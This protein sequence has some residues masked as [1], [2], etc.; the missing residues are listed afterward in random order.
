MSEVSSG[1][2]IFWVGKHETDRREG[3]VG[4]AIRTSLLDRVESPSS[5]SDRIMRTR[6]SLAG[7][8]HLTLLSIYA[9]TLQANEQILDSFYGC[10]RDTIAM[11]P[12]ADKLIL[13][14]DFNAR[15]GNDNQTWNVLGPFGMG[16]MNS[17]GLRLLELCSEFDLNICNTFF[18]QKTIHKAT[19]YHPRSKH[20]HLIDYIIT[21]KRDFSDVCSVR[22]MR[23]AECGTDHKL[24]RGKFKLRIRKRIRMGGVKVPKRIDVSKLKQTDI[25]TTVTERLNELD[26]DG[27]WENFRDQVYSVGADVLGFKTR[28]HRD[29]FDENCT[30]INGLLKTKHELHEK[31][32]N[33]D[34]AIKPAAV[35]AYKDHK[36]TLQRELRRMKND[37]WKNIASDI[38]LAFNAK[39]SKSFYGLLRQVFGPPT[40]SVTPL[41]TKDGADIVKEPKEMLQRWEEHFTDLFHNP[42][43]VNQKIIDSLPQC[44]IVHNMD[45]QPTSDEV[46]QAIKQINSGKAPG[47]DGIPVDLLKVESHKMTEMITVLIVDCWNGTPVPQDWI[48]GTLISLYKG[49]GDK[50]I[51]GNYRGITL[52]AAV[53]KI[54]ARIL[55]NRLEADICPVAIPESQSGFRGGRGTVD[56]IFTARQIQEK[57]I[58]QQIPLY[59][60]FVD[61]TKAFD[62][63]NRDALWIVLGK[64]GCPP[65]F[66]EMVKQ[67]HRD[68]RARVTFNGE[69]SGEIPVENGVKQG[70]ILAPTLFS[71]FFAA[72]LAHAFRDCDRGVGLRFRTT[73]KVFDLRRFNAKSKTFQALIIELLYADDA[74]FVAHTEADMQHIMDLFSASCEAFG[75]TISL[76]KTKAMFTPAPG[77]PYIEPSILVNGTRLGV[78]EKFVYLGSTLTRDGSLDAEIYQRI[79][80]ASVA[81]G[82]LEKRLWSVRDITNHTKIC[83]YRACILTT[84]LYASETWTLLRKHIKILERFQQKC[85]RRILN[86][87]WESRTPDTDVLVSAKCL[88]VEA[89]LIS[90]QMRW[91]GHII[92]M[93][94][95]RIPKQ[96]F[97]GELCIGKRPQHKPKKRFKDCI[98]SN[99][100]QMA[101]DIGKW[102][103][104]ALDRGEWRSHI[105]NACRLFEESRQE[106]NR[107]KRRLRK[108]DNH[109][110][111]G[112]WTCK[113]CQRILL[114]KAG[115][116]NHVKSHQ[117]RHTLDISQS[118]RNAT[119]EARMDRSLSCHLCNKLCKSSAGL[120]S[121]LRGHAR[122]K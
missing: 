82:K 85:L 90:H 71:I 75:L 70:D 106:H 50:S 109:G 48:D 53:G 49:K 32:L 65:K 103:E 98:K 69:L 19:W 43:I 34:L 23:S 27:S 35:K 101:F 37:W 78:V 6:V 42:S 104:M 68:M 67:L 60:V 89:L 93:E 9:P 17:S 76:N 10:L 16:K 28:K 120:A 119:S 83:V 64:V 102:E 111:D 22:V 116:V 81:F 95:H 14:G 66:V 73:G 99:L 54:F 88:S 30:H 108:G 39:D 51:C 3:G 8:R 80:K 21:R 47:R 74:D 52:L 56:M 110:F 25:C 45:R 57:C 62:T 100:K 13:L 55:L 36:S 121:H 40:S 61:L 5:V 1:F 20:G 79:Q 44:N 26:Y 2:T 59:Q 87:K 114:S 97:Y 46:R 38:Q 11:T 41:K 58:E 31:L 63:V 29:W 107:L 7:G 72:L 12:A 112:G 118:K 86:I 18:R 33:Q 115:W 92:R 105:K 84:L 77:E 96:I 113:I 15:V 91:T 24:V 94:D 4:F 122:R 117:K